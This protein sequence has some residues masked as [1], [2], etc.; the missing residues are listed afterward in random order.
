VLRDIQ[1]AMHD[2]KQQYRKLF[3]DSALKTNGLMAT[4]EIVG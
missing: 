1:Q 4:A 3:Q 2:A